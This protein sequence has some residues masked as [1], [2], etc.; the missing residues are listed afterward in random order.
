MRLSII[1]LSSEKL[2]NNLS[3][4]TIILIITFVMSLY[5]LFKITS[6]TKN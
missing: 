5:F 2:M 6:S 1:S 3:S 4:L